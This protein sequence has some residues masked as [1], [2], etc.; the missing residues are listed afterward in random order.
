MD[1][2]FSP[3][4]GDGCSIKLHS[5]KT[6]KIYHVLIKLDIKLGY[7]ILIDNLIKN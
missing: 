4:L 7:L 2:I 3:I 5:K 6:S 1:D